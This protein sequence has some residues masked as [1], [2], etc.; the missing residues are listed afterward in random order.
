MQAG[1]NLINNWMAEAIKV[2]ALAAAAGQQTG[3]GVTKAA[4]VVAAMAP[5]AVQFAAQNGL[6]APTAASLNT[7]NT[8]VVAALNAIG[9]L[10]PPA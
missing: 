9:A 3:S 5:E 6:P 1:I 2:E 4:A 7:I 10:T 8:S